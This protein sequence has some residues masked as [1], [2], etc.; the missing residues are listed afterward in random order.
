[1]SVA[2]ALQDMMSVPDITHPVTVG[3][4]PTRGIVDS[5]GQLVP[6]AGTDVQFVGTVL[7]LIKDSV[8]G[9][10]TGAAVQVG[11]LGALAL[12]GSPTVYKLGRVMPIED[13]LLLACECGGG[14]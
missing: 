4:A 3:G 13:G 5:T 6:L 9:I 14:R 7:Y 8:P 12:G 2:A 1:M 10:V 11:P